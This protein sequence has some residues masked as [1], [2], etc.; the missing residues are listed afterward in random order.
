MEYGSQ[1]GLQSLVVSILKVIDHLG[2]RRCF[3]CKEVAGAVVPCS[4]K[5]CKNEVHPRCAL[6]AELPYTITW[7]NSKPAF[8]CRCSAHGTGTAKTRHGT[9]DANDL[10]HGPKQER[11]P[12]TEDGKMLIGPKLLRVFV[13][14]GMLK[15]GDVRQRELCLVSD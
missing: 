14:T 6:N 2:E 12:K 5:D 8:S 11:F 1:K 13:I 7:E 9:D 4:E 15:E 10:G 3:E